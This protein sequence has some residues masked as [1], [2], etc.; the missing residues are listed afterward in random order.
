MGLRITLTIISE[1][2]AEID[3]DKLNEELKSNVIDEIYETA[4]TT[5]GF[6]GPFEIV[7]DELVIAEIND[8]TDF[9]GYGITTHIW[10]AYNDETWQIIG[11]N[12][13]KGK[14]IFELDIEGN[15]N[16]VITIT[17][18]VVTIEKMSDIL[19]RAA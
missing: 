16:E 9:E 19:K 17:P 13:I 4:K 3:I 14:I 1:T 10:G 11:A 12:L 8:S 5:S 18:N 15:E 6:T 7:A 2:D